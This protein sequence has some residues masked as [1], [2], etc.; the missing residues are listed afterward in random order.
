MCYRLNILVT[1]KIPLYFIL[2]LVIICMHVTISDLTVVPVLS[3]R[4]CSRHLLNSPTSVGTKVKAFLHLLKSKN[5]TWMLLHEEQNQN[6]PLLLLQ[7]I[8]WSSE[9]FLRA[10]VTIRSPKTLY[11]GSRT[12]HFDTTLSPEKDT[13]LKEA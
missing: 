8:K 13:D 11:N 6:F 12:H 2:Y 4:Q 9:S 3:L 10:K 7:D 5:E 1:L